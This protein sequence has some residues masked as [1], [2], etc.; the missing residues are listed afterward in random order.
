MIFNRS[1]GWL[2]S[3]LTYACKLLVFWV[4]SLVFVAWRLAVW[5]AGWLVSRITFVCELPVSQPCCRC[6]V[7]RVL[8]GR[9]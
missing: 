1:V 4:V 6:L 7:F 8:Y 2:V 5:S 3:Q 9:W